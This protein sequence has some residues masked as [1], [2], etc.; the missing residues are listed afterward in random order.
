MRRCA[1]CALTRFPVDGVILQ[2]ADQGRCDCNEC[3]RYGDTEYHSRLDIRV[4]EYVRGGWPEKT[5]AVSGWGMDLSD[6]E[7]LP[8]LV[9][10][11]QRIDYLIDVPDSTRRHDPAYRRSLIRALQCSFGTIGGPQA[12]PPQHWAR[13]RWFL[14]TAKNQGEHLA[15]LHADD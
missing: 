8:H 2:S 15:G 6:P 4:R 9:S 11:S 14:P 10:L 5:I 3:R 12:E 1:D 7:S 13:D